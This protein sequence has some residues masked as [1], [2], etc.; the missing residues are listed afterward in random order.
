MLSIPQ[1]NID[2][3][4][5]LL[6]TEADPTQR[7]LITRLLAEQTELLAEEQLKAATA[8]PVPTSA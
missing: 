4:K 5:L 8:G 1:A 7:T 3:F 2:K 6:E